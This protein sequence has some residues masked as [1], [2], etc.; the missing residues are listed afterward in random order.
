[1]QKTLT[2]QLIEAAIKGFE[3]QKAEI[4][5]EIAELRSMLP[6]GSHREPAASTATT[7][8]PR[9]KFSAASRRKMAAAQRA[10]YANLRGRDG[11]RSKLR[12]RRRDPA[13]AKK[14]SRKKAVA[15]NVAE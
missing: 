15:K 7:E 8:R 9:K 6:G 1:M 3:A 13:I 12:R 11:G 14:S 4:D 2:P 10:R 5:S